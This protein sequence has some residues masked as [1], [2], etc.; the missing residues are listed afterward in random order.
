MTATRTLPA[1]VWRIADYDDTGKTVSARM[2]V[3]AGDAELYRD[4]QHG[5]LLPESDAAIDNVGITI[6]RIRYQTAQGLLFLNRSGAI[7]SRRNS[8]IPA[9]NT[10]RAIGRL[11]Y[12]PP[13]IRS[14]GTSLPT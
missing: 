10:T 3:V 6:N 11:S 7:R 8:R 4:G 2:Y 13:P 5:T 1:F 14:H 9:A 12:P